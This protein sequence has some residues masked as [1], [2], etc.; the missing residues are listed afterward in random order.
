MAAVL[1]R[2]R[3]RP[4]P[5]VADVF[6]IEEVPIRKELVVVNALVLIIRA[7]DN[8]RIGAIVWSLFV[9]YSSCVFTSL[10]WN[11]R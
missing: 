9:M 7:S 4:I 10:Q 6:A 3:E 2:E 8:E 5:R 11:M 1:A